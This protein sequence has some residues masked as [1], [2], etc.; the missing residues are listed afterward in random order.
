MI[1]DMKL[2][3]EMFTGSRNKELIK[4]QNQYDKLL[5]QFSLRSVMRRWF[6][7]EQ[8]AARPYGNIEVVV[9]KICNKF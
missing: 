4:I 3:V 6:E 1:N 2:I 9:L 7:S 5:L 8:G